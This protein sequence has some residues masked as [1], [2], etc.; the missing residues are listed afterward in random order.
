MSYKLAALCAAIPWDTD[1]QHYKQKE[2]EA[3]WSSFSEKKEKGFEPCFVTRRKNSDS[4]AGSNSNTATF[5]LLSL[6]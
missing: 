1:E 6:K 4:E 2:S 5:Y 3:K